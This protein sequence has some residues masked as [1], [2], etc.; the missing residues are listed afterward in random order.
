MMPVHPR[1]PTPRRA[2]RRCGCSVT[3]ALLA[4]LGGFI[5]Q[6]FADSSQADDRDRSLDWSLGGLE[7]GSRILRPT[8]ARAGGRFA[9]HVPCAGESHR[10][11][12]G[13]CQ[14]WDGGSRGRSSQPGS[15]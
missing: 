3:L 8:A 11:Q 5:P 14:P 1:P 4:V 12:G 13:S 2:P 6:S 10:R 15:R 9:E 7:Q